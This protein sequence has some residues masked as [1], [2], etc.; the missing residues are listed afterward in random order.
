M[1]SVIV[2][3]KNDFLFDTFFSNIK[4]TIGIE[5]EIIKI[6]NALGQF[7][8][9]EAYNEGLV[10]AKY[11][12]VVF[13]HEDVAFLTQ[14]WG[15][16]LFKY[17]D[18]IP[19]IGCIGIAGALYKTKAPSAW[20]DVEADKR[21]M[22]LIQHTDGEKELHCTGWQSDE[23]FKEVAVVDGVFLATKKSYGF[24]FD[25]TI[26]GFH[27]YDLNLS[28]EAKKKGYS[29]LVT[30]EI[31]IEH[32]SLGSVNKGWVVSSSIFHKTYADFLPI[33]VLTS[34]KTN[35]KAEFLNLNRFIRLA[36]DNNLKSITLAYWLRLI[37]MKPF[38]LGTHYRIFKSV[39]K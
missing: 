2:C 31:L 14:N 7:S 28:V 10:Q 4:V 30:K 5:H 25:T 34:E 33:S 29:V 1:I 15:L 21:I 22:H 16:I 35:E 3:S 18:S 19:N 9:S 6:A 37:I 13:V 26:L 20:W 11:E 24:Q 36:I 23:R 27:C 38:A 8:I 17:F 39:F 12:I 32:F